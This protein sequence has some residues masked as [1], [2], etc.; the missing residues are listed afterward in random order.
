MAAADSRSSQALGSEVFGD[1]TEK[2]EIVQGQT[3]MIFGVHYVT[4]VAL[5]VLRQLKPPFDGDSLLSAVRRSLEIAWAVMVPKFATDVDLHA[6]AMRAGFLVAGSD[7]L[8]SYI[9]GCMSTPGAA[10]IPTGPV[11]DDWQCIVLGAESHGANDHFQG[12]LASAFPTVG[13][14]ALPGLQVGVKMAEAAA[15]TIRAMSQVDRTV[16]GPVRYRVQLATGECATGS[17]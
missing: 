10:D 14:S 12:Q 17:L 7:A 5:N 2:L 15:V 11:R 13:G 9:G 8:G 16:G 4:E 1:E 3:M 6:P